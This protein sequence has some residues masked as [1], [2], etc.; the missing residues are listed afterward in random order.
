MSALATAVSSAPLAYASRP[1][2]RAA[3]DNEGLIIDLFAGG[4]GASEAILQATGR[5]PDIAV[6]HDR[7]AISM[8][9]VN[10]PGT[11]HLCD[12]IRAV[13]IRATLARF[14]GRFVDL[15]WAS[16]DCKDHS[17]AKGGVPKDK[18]I[19]GL[20]WEVLRWAAAIRRATGRL[21][22]IIALENVEEFADWGPLHRYGKNANRVN[23]KRRGELFKLWVAQLKSLGFHHVEWREL[24]AADYGAPTTRK[25]LFLIAR[26]D[27]GAIVWPDPTHAKVTVVGDLFAKQLLAWRPAADVIDWTIPIPSIFGRK[28]PL[29]E[30]THKRLAR[31][32]QRF[33]IEA[34][35]PFIVPV[36]H[37]KGGDAVRST[38]E[39][40]K[41]ATTA[42]G[43]ELAF[44]APVLMPVTHGGALDRAY[45][46]MGAFPTVTAAPRGEQ[47]LVS[48]FLKPRYGERP[49]QDPRVRSITDAAPAVVPTGNG[50]DLAGVYLARQFGST[51]SGRPLD[52][53]HPAV[54]SD[55][56]GGKSQLVAVHMS[57]IAYGD[58][59][60]RAGL[61]A[62]APTAPIGAV[63][64]ANDKTL[65]SAHLLRT[66]MQSAA[67]RNCIH[68]V[69]EPIRTITSAGG[70][71][72]AG[73]TLAGGTFGVGGRAGQSPPRAPSA[74]LNTVTSKADRAISVASIS[75]M[76][77]GS[78]GSDLQFPLLTGLSHS[79]DALMAVH[80]DQ[81]NGDQIGRPASEPVT[82]LTLRSTQQKL[83]AAVVDKYY[84]TGVAHGPDRPFGA[85]TSKGRF[86]LSSA[87]IEQANTGMVGHSV[88]KPLSTIVGGGGPG[89][90][91]STTQRLIDVSLEA[92]CEEIGAPAGSRRREVLEFLWEHFGQPTASEW[93]DPT[94]TPRGRLRFGL[95]NI[96]GAVFQI[97]DIG[98]RMLTP[99]ELYR[100]QGFSD[101]YVIDVTLEG[102]KLSK[103]AQTRMA[104]NSVSPP[105]AAALLTSNLPERMLLRRAA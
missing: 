61:R 75:R 7:E 55:G 19:R 86:S 63:T 71:A 49:G 105:P 45:S 38:S 28:R 85:A 97:V 3:N 17:K 15:M 60:A 88:E 29:K 80:M 24:V 54:M 72:L 34:P 40:L 87:F 70:F 41:T 22:S 58:G 98:M 82:T 51:V 69:G 26:S 12:D 99:R 56:A 6:N 2:A 33:V 68:P 48:A 74:P 84:G 64:G 92:A 65:V 47:A 79:K 39:P 50:G 16:P 11:L 43:G 62:T 31:G 20:A 94:A 35:N 21:P 83:A 53:P 10:H 8:H 95:V 91:W 78:I 100:A 37:T 30:K 77:K 73:L 23:K 18:N 67:D 76:S 57:S 46:P 9:A 96:D 66:D 102:A 52:E 36:T 14:P 103:T 59:W 90:G 93:T 32:I 101:D 13:D 81:H 89:I 1:A 5:H 42:K 27:G 25:R 44:G 104:G 4:G